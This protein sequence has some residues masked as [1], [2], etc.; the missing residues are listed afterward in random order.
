MKIIGSAQ[1]LKLA[2]SGTLMVLALAGCAAQSPS[3]TKTP[4]ASATTTP[5][6]SATPTPTLP[7]EMTPAEAKA[8]FKAIAKSSCNKAQAEGVVETGADYTIVMVNKND[9]YKDYSAAY[10]SG[11]K[12]VLV[13]ELTGLAS[14]SDW[15]TFSMADEAGQEAAI[16]VVFNT[17][18]ASFTATQD[19]GEFGVSHFNYTVVDGLIA[20]STNLDPK[21]PGTVAVRYGNITDADRE[22]IITAVDEFLAKQ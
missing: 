3:P 4:I 9:A 21:K 11:G 20:T 1:A 15:Y 5:S 16:D 13:W 22:V 8:A 19:N 14:C 18:D 12:Y 10:V 7:A 2:A 17:A 6:A